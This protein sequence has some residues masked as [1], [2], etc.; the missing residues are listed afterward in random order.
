MYILR[1]CCDCLKQAGYSAGRW[2][3]SYWKQITV[4]FHHDRIS[5]LS[6]KMQVL[7]FQGVLNWIPINRISKIWSKSQF[8][9]RLYLEQN[10]GIRGPSS[11][12]G[13]RLFQLTEIM[14]T[15]SVLEVWQKGFRETVSFLSFIFHTYYM[16]TQRTLHVL[17]CD[18]LSQ[19]WSSHY[20]CK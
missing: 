7:L 9:N 16:Y 2:W 3:V 19:S 6:A 12:T 13:K 15:A 5:G 8:Q 4:V 17:D 1:V 14:L 18:F 10:T 20:I 11:Q